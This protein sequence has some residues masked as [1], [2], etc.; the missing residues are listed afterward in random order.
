[1]FNYDNT[2]KMI[3]RNYL[4]N[5]FFSVLKYINNWIVF[6]LV[7]YFDF[8]CEI[9][10][11]IKVADRAISEIMIESQKNI[12]SFDHLLLLEYLV[13]CMHSQVQSPPRIDMSRK[14]LMLDHF[15]PVNFCSE[16]YRT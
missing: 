10:E 5:S 14:I 11:Q 7:W 9:F 4:R 13:F 15:D 2:D 6:N 1:M 8:I 3:R 16:W 12:F